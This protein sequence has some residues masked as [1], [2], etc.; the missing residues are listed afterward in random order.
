[1]L[2]SLA[3]LERISSLCRYPSLTPLDCIG[4][5]SMDIT[6]PGTASRIAS[7][8]KSY[9]ALL[10]LQGHPQQ[11][12]LVALRTYVFEVENGRASYTPVA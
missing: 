7:M 12:R 5:R 2:E 8:A 10:E 6:L 3:N 1:M 9:S 4:I 11:V